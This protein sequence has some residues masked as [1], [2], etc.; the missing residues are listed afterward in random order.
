MGDILFLAHRVPYPPDRGDKIRSFNILKWLCD[1][2]TVHLATFADD[3][4]DL[5][6]AEVLR[7]M[8]GSLHIEKRTISKPVGA[9]KALTSGKPIS[10]T[11][12]DSSGIR[13]F[14]RQTLAKKP[15]ETIFVFSGQ[16]AQFVP[17][18]PSH[19]GFVMD[20]VDMDSAKFAEYA[21]TVSGPRNLVH[22]REGRKLFAFEKNIAERAD[23]SL[24]VSTAETALFR[25]QT[26]LESSKIRTLENG[27]DCDFFNPE[28]SIPTAN[29]A[30]G[31]PL[32]VFTGQMD[33]RPNIEA[34]TSF[35][36]ETL[37]A[38]RAE[39]PDVRF[40]IV[41]RN[42]GNNVRE[43]ANQNG[44]IVT[45]G[46]PD[47]R[48]WLVAAD[49][50]VASLRMAR[51]IQNK[52]LEAMAM[53]KPVVVSRQAFEGIDAVPGRDLLVAS[54]IASEAQAVLELI[55]NP[56]SAKIMGKSARTQMLNRYSW[57]T[58]LAPLAEMIGRPCNDAPETPAKAA[59]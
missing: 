26:G 25:E 13:A 54:D 27:I 50:G 41:G 3:D 16:M 4:A 56:A 37:P 55:E 39:R 33:Y 57:G 11:M 19:I 48:S 22:V 15:V 17:D 30:T 58:T 49:I 43:L 8:L 24:F 52:V 6:H 32:L 51:G 47:I 53:E 45:G 23:Y 59:A 40:A 2:A 44:V 28:N 20:F 14:V 31:G 7:P 35:A 46:V 1:K 10:L 42:P 12:F 5:Q 36:R 9:M 29:I 38:I 18:L 34:V 21:Q